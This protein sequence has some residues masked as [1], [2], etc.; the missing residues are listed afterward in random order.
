MDSRLI[1][2]HL[3]ITQVRPLLFLG[4]GQPREGK[5]FRDQQGHID[6]SIIIQKIK[7][8]KVVITVMSLIM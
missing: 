4:I 3:K 8:K 1:G 7:K 5:S 6:Q 2:L